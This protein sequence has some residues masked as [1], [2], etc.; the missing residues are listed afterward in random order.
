MIRRQRSS[1][2]IV[3][4]HR[5]VVPTRTFIECVRRH[6]PDA[7]VIVID[8]DAGRSCT[9]AFR[10]E[11]GVIVL[12]GDGSLWWGGAINR[13]IDW[14]AAE[15]KLKDDDLVILANNDVTFDS[16]LVAAL[17]PH[18]RNRTICHPDVVDTTGRSIGAGRR[19]VSWIPYVTRR[20][21]RRRRTCR[22]DLATARF[23][24]MTWA[25]LCAVG[26]IHP[27]LPQY[28][29]DNEFS[30]RARRMGISTVQVNGIH[31]TVDESATGAKNTN[32]I[33]FGEF[34]RSLTSIRS[35]NNL[36]YRYRFAAANVGPVLA[37]PVVASMTANSLAKTARNIARRAIRRI[38]G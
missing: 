37:V 25:T 7:T 31:C 4:V 23:L 33:A 32:L 38:L 8:D 2:I 11:H 6:L 35:A 12:P 1:W 17:L 14:L 5:K 10:G 24:C 26:R 34:L 16:P 36:L 19:L 21:D 9:R 20:P 3:P 30:L 28:Q 13:G 27:L 29:G 15:V 18:L 22:I